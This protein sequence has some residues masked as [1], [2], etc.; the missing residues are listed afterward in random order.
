M[1]IR[2]LFAF[3]IAFQI[4]FAQNKNSAC[5]YC[6]IYEGKLNSDVKDDT[7]HI[8]VKLELKRDSIYEYIIVG[9]FST[10]TSTTFKGTGKWFSEMDILF[11]KPDP[12][13]EG[14]VVFIFRDTRDEE[15]I[16][17]A[18]ADLQSKYFWKGFDNSFKI[19]LVVI[20]KAQSLLLWPWEILGCPP[21]FYGWVSPLQYVPV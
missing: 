20:G 18:E 15:K 12:N 3:I 6:G 10:C 1:K 5:G 17:K 16:P 11:L 8:Y 13:E 7:A 9:K 4:F 19:S 2:F 14:V 21:R